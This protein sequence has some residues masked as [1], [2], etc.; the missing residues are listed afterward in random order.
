[1]YY[2]LGMDKRQKET[3]KFALQYLLANHDD[4]N[5][6]EHLEDSI[7]SCDIKDQHEYLQSIY[8]AVMGLSV[9]MLKG[10]TMSIIL[11]TNRKEKKQ[12]LTILTKQGSI[13][14]KQ[15]KQ[16]YIEYCKVVKK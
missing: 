13:S 12:R 1:M 8:E 6:I 3:I 2:T 10:I 14:T 4:E 15:A 9:F 16:M 5:V 11:Q 7:Q